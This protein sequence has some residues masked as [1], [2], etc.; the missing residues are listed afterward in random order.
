LWFKGEEVLRVTARKDQW[1]EAEEFICNTCR[2][3][4]KRKS[5]WIIEGPS[6]ISHHSVISTN[7]YMSLNVA[8]VE[9][10]KHQ[11]ALGFI[12]MKTLDK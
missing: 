12:H 10:L 5:D 11:K 8:K 7:H 9:I 1:G 6:P 3:E 4:K 2:F